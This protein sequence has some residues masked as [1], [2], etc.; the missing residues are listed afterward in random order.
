MLYECVRELGKERDRVIGEVRIPLES[1]NLKVGA[2]TLAHAHLT[3][4][5][6]YGSREHTLFVGCDMIRGISHA[7]I[8][9]HIW[10]RER[11]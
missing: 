3:L 1:W 5:M 11:F 2:E 9:L 7:V 4:L 6:W 10:K 8:H